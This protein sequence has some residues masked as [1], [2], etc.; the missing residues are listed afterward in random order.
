MSGP[1]AILVRS[2]SQ[3]A[4]AS[5]AARASYCIEPS[6]HSG[7]LKIVW[8]SLLRAFFLTVAFGL[9][10]PRHR[11]VPTSGSPLAAVRTRFHGQCEPCRFTRRHDSHLDLLGHPRFVGTLRQSSCRS[12][13][14]ARIVLGGCCA[15]FHSRCGSD[16][17][18][19][20]ILMETRVTSCT[21]SEASLSPRMAQFTPTLPASNFKNASPASGTTAG[22]ATEP[23]GTTHV[24][25]AGKVPAVGLNGRPRQIFIFQALPASQALC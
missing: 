5:V 17:R 22:P 9:L 7:V 11:D 10:G 25:W 16:C 8:S 13:T 14:S 19:R 1:V 15:C 20:C 23:T 3:A 2:R 21:P 6:P 24:F 4:K 18:C 12:G